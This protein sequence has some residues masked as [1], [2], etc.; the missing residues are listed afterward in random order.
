MRP[1]WF[2]FPAVASLYAVD[3]EFMLGPALLAAPVLDEGVQSRSVTL[4]A[5]PVWYDAATGAT[6]GPTEPLPGSVASWRIWTSRAVQQGATCQTPL[7][8]CQHRMTLSRLQALPQYHAPDKPAESSRAL[9]AGHV[10][11]CTAKRRVLMR[12]L[13]RSDADGDG[14]VMPTGEIVRSGT[15]EVPVTLD[16][17]PVYLRGGHIVPRRERARRSTAAMHGDP[18]TL[19]RPASRRNLMR[20]PV[21]EGVLHNAETGL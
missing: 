21:R 18:L 3:D 2:E 8:R 4:P 10:K 9:L 13:G 7:E 19:V 1:L 15:F 6:A 20:R 14:L 17:V 12:H 11:N 5:G 16:T